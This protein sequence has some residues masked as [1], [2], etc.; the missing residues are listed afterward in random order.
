MQNID[1]FVFISLFS[2]LT[3]I[4]VGDFYF[5]KSKNIVRKFLKILNKRVCNWYIFLVRVKNR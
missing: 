3:G 4:G 2:F 1:D 5:D